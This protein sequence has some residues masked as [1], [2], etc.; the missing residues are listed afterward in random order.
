M[1]V[2]IKNGIAIKSYFIDAVFELKL[3]HTEVNLK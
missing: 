2:K 3:V 1:P